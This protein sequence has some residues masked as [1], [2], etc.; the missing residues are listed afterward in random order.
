VYLS[1]SVISQ[2]KKRTPLSVTLNMTEDPFFKLKIARIGAGTVTCPFDVIRAIS[3]SSMNIS[4]LSYIHTLPAYLKIV[5]GITL[6][7]QKALLFS[8]LSKL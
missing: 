3:T 6:D 2:G 7:V 8:A 5:K 1:L 4:L